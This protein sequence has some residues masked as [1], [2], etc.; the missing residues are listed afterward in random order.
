[1]G[2][3]T[4]TYFLFATP[5]NAPL[6][7]VVGRR[8]LWFLKNTSSSDNAGWNRAVLVFNAM[9][10]S[11]VSANTIAK[12][13]AQRKVGKRTGHNRRTE[14]FFGLAADASH[15]DDVITCTGTWVRFASKPLRWPTPTQPR[16]HWCCCSFE[17]VE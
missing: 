15:V 10:S 11:V 1:M 6:C 13:T 12:S 4:T 7:T 2:S 17:I 8:G 3:H 9:I 16:A 14:N 5:Q